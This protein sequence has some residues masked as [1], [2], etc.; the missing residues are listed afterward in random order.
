MLNR[1]IPWVRRVPL[2]LTACLALAACSTGVGPDEGSGPPPPPTG[3][4]PA[5]Q[6]NTPG[7]TGIT[8][9]TVFAAMNLSEPIG[10]AVLGSTS[11]SR[12][13][14]ASLPPGT[15]AEGVSL[16]IVNHRTGAGVTAP[17]IAGGVDPV[18]IAAAAGDT[19]G[20]TVMSA[21]GQTVAFEKIKVVPTSQP[22]IVVRTEPIQGKRDVPLNARIL[23]VFSEPVDPGTFTEG[24]L[25]L[26]TGGVAVAGTVAFDDPEHLRAI[27]TPTA[28]LLPE[29][30]Y[31]LLVAG[32]IQNVAGNPLIAPAPVTFTSAPAPT[33]SVY[34]RVT[35]DAVT[36]GP[37]YLL[38]YSDGTFAIKYEAPSDWPPELPL[39]TWWTYPGTYQASGTD[40]GFLF[41]GY[42]RA[43]PW[44]ATATRSGTSISVTFNFIMQMSGFD[45]GTYTLTDGPGLP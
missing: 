21:Q 16:N 41:D 14:Y 30:D 42:A 31:T 8:P 28:P 33:L 25:Q 26:Q 34:S 37:S 7:G 36:N 32:T 15:L 43:G 10:A 13:V 45:D 35:P 38:M 6:C 2:A 23:V 3:C 18:A 19:L 11:G 5:P 29:V 27:F 39:P 40:I 12:M 9:A 4:V 22:P 20:F 1:F 17:I 44:I 24:V